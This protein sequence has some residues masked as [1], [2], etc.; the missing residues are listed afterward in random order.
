MTQCNHYFVN[1]C[2]FSW[3]LWS[4]SVAK[5]RSLDQTNKSHDHDHHGGGADLVMNWLSWDERKREYKVVRLVWDFVY[6][7]FSTNA[8]DC[9]Q[10]WYKKINRWF[11]PADLQAIS[12]WSCESRFHDSSHGKLSRDMFCMLDMRWGL[13]SIC[14]RTRGSMVTWDSKFIPQ[15]LLPSWY[16]WWKA[17]TDTESGDKHSSCICSHI[18]LHMNMI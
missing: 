18:L 12:K 7:L 8:I 10:T 16:D 6:I 15:R 13:S 2:K 3:H 1:K 17:L 5:E 9:K 14:A 11:H 4:T